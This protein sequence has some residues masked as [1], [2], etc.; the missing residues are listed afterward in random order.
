MLGAG[1]AFCR[2]RL[3]N[4]SINSKKSQAVKDFDAFDDSDAFDANARPY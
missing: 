4:S 1:T 3:P 2:I